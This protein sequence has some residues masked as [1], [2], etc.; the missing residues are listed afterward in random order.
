MKDHSERVPGKNTRS[1]AGR[2][3]FHNILATLEKTRWNRVKAAHLLQVSYKTL[4]KK[5]KDC[6][7]SGD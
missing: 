6:G 4:L 7:L 3:L 5:M 1:F 2:P